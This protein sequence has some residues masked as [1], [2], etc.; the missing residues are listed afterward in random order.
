MKKFSEC[1]TGTENDPDFAQLYSIQFIV[2]YIS[3]WIML[4]FKFF[5]KLL[6]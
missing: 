5:R 4:I 6:V 2:F 3:T 1:T